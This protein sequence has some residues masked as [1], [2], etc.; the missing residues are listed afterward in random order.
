M[1]MNQVEHRELHSMEE[2]LQNYKLARGK[3]FL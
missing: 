3:G 1:D 2:E